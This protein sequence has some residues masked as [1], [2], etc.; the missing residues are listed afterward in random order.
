M[1]EGST[2]GLGRLLRRY[3][4]RPLD[5]VSQACEATPKREGPNTLWERCRVR[6]VRAPGDT[7]TERLFGSILERDGRFKFV[8][9][10]NDF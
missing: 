6:H 8:G 3:E 2:R 1:S 9:Y 10:A 7:V 5:V 4:G